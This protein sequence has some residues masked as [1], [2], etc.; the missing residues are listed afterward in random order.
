[1]RYVSFMA[2]G[3]RWGALVE[4]TVVDLS[5]HAGLPG[6]LAAFVKAG[7]QA[8][9]AAEQAVRDGRGTRRIALDG[10][11]LLA[12]LPRPSSLR[13][14]YAFERH[15]KTAYANRGRE[16]PPEWYEIPVFYFSNAAS[17]IGPEAAVRRPPGSLALDYELEV[18]CVIGVGGK[19]IE[20]EAAAEHIFGFTILNDWSARD[21]QARETRVGL[22]PAKGKDFATSLGPWIVTP[23]E[24][25]DRA[26]GRPGV[27]DLAMQARVN[28]ERR[29]SG[30]WNELHHSFG[31]MIARAS[32]GVALEPGDVLGSGTVGTGCLL[33]LTRGQGPWLQRGDVVELEIDRLGVLRNHV[34][35]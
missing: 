20:A 6:S 32:S 17:V 15:A 9:A 18:A 27:Y 10:L 26:T 14:F 35:D 28:G 12:P 29:S 25:A 8:W 23:D 1:M 31:D 30:N 2:R 7:P 3:E 33:E 11:D 16:L 34:V 21:V 4:S 24:L 5:G 13:D 22:G 19:E